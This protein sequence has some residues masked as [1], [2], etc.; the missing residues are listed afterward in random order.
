MN[1]LGDLVEA[2]APVL[3]GQPI[4][5]TVSRPAVARLRAISRLRRLR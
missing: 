5:F 2:D 4:S 3:G 1:A